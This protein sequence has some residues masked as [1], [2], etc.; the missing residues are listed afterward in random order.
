MIVIQIKGR[1]RWSVANE[2]TVY[3]SNKDQ[4]RKPTVQEIQHYVQSGRSEFTLCPGDVLY[5][6][7]GHIHNASTVLND[8]EALGNSEPLDNCP[9]SYPTEEMA[10]LLNWN[11]PS[12]HL[13]FGIEQSCEGTLEALLHHA[14]RLHFDDNRAFN[15]VAISA[16]S[17]YSR[18]QAASTHDIRWEA[19]LHHAL[20][21]V[22]RERHVCDFPSFHG[23]SAKL[24]DCKGSASLR[25]SLPLGL[26]E[27]SDSM[28]YSQLKK[29]FLHAL[30][31]FIS[32][33]SITATAAFVQTLQTPPTDPELFFCFPGYSFEHVVTCPDSLMSLNAREFKQVLTDFYDK[34]STN[35]HSA[36][37]YFDKFG[38]AIR[39]KNRKQQ[40]A[41][42]EMVAQAKS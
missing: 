39:E 13:T 16:K 4:K 12:L 21:A 10:T 32:S 34:A 18:N 37:R 19:V 33:A 14:L 1:K 30:D 26:S 31:V 11:G 6:P 28:Q 42:L 41:D 22:A 40:L 2:P 9:S 27:Q 7:R 15:T 5:I 35:F 25:R 3:L 8:N 24:K 29:A 36:L 23:I 20:A 38:S 17:C